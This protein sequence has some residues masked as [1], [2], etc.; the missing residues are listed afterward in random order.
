MKLKKTTLKN[1]VRVIT[2]PTPG[3]PSVTVMVMA[4]VGSNYET[5]SQ[6]GLSHFLEHMLFKGSAKRPSHINLTRELDSLGAQYN[7]FT[8][9]EATAYYAKADK[10]HFKRIF[11]IVADMY[12]HPLLPPDELERERGVILEEIS[13]YEDLPQRKV[14]DVLA[15]LMYGDTP[16]GRTILGP[17]ENIKKFTRK[18]FINY[19]Q[20]YYVADKTIVIV[21]GDVKEAEVL[22][23]AKKAF[24][25]IPQSKRITKKKVADKQK[26]PGIKIEKRKSDQSHLLLAFRTFSAKDK[27]VPSLVLISTLLGGGMSSRLYQRLREAMGACYYIYARHDESTDHGVFVISTGINASRIQEVAGAIIEECKRL[28]EELVSERELDMVKEYHLGHL[29]MD[30]ETSDAVANYFGDQE[31]TT[32]K[33]HTSSEWE[34]MIR[35]VTPKDIQ[36]VAKEVFRN[37]KVNLAAVGN[38]TDMAAVRQELKF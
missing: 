12:Q 15:S 26:V 6:N 3:N 24:K 36:Q 8:A 14:W 25:D 28:T 23:E 5:K 27:R 19:I 11:D 37:D 30:L 34:E 4:E 20:K 21:S 38:I 7:A 35:K 17:R 18:D 22:K 29:H 13:M 2:V 16:A 9:N 1:G 32:G 33:P 10:K 31:I